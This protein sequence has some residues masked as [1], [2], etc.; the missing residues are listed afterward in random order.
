MRFY[1]SLAVACIFTTVTSYAAN[2][3]INKSGSNQ[4]FCLQENPR[5]F[6]DFSTKSTAMKYAVQDARSQAEYACSA[7]GGAVV[8][9]AENN[10][11]CT[12]ITGWLDSYVC[13]AN[14]QVQCDLSQASDAK[15]VSQDQINL[16]IN[17]LEHTAKT[18]LYISPYSGNSYL[19]SI[20]P[21]AQTQAAC[22][23]AISKGYEERLQ[24]C[25]KNSFSN[26]SMASTSYALKYC[27]LAG[28]RDLIEQYL[29]AFSIYD[30][31]NFEY[32]YKQLIGSTGTGG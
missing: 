9:G 3:A 5:C 13:M 31:Y 27:D 19:H 11:N 24:S 20:A 15:N 12:S 29:A 6:L 32:I 14:Y 8:S 30:G 25:L 22:A 1:Y 23:G 17:R 16:C 18:S 10:S 2:V 26:D 28:R 7:A 21:R 4:Q